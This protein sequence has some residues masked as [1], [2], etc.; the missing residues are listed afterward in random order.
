MRVRDTLQLS[1]QVSNTDR[2]GSAPSLDGAEYI[3]PMTSAVAPA[4]LN[5]LVE[6]HRRFLLFLERRVGSREVAED[7]LHDAFVKSLSRTDSVPDEDGALIA[8]FYRV[9]R[10][11]IVDHYRRVGAETRALAHVAGTADEFEPPHDAELHEAVCAC[12]TGLVETLKPEYAAVIRRVDL[13]GVPVVEFAREAGITPGNAGVRLHRA[14][15]ALRKQ[16]AL[17][18]NTCADHGCFDC[19]CGGPARHTQ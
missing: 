9:L 15:A 11:A 10:N 17:S 18:C 16:L 3:H 12:I 2:V 1:E 7:I 19:R 4:T 13:D 5:V 8:W 6:N 14:H